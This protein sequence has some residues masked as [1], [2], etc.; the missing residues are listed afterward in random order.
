MLRGPGVKRGALIS[1][2]ER[3]RAFEAPGVAGRKQLSL[4]QPVDEPSR[5]DIDEQGVAEQLVA[6][7]RAKG[8]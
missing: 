3:E 8:V 5:S 4:D 2:A 6:Q 1:K 7:P